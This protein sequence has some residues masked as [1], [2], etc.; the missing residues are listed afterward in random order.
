MSKFDRH[1]ERLH[2]TDEHGHRVFIFPDEIK[3][4]WKKRRTIV[5]WF[6]VLLFLGLPWIKV[7]GEQAVL[8][9]IA[10]RKFAFFGKVFWGHDAPLLIFV[11]LGF[12]V[13]MGILT[14][15]Y[16]RVWCGWACPQTVFI[17]TIFRR[18]E[19]F[20]EGSARRR[21][22]LAKASMSI[23]KLTKK[24]M[25]WILFF[26]ASTILTH[27]FLAYFVGAY[28]LH[29]I[30]TSSPTENGGKFL[31]MFI[32]NMII[33]FDFAWFRE[34]FCIIMCPYGRI[35]SV[36]MDSS[37]LVVGYDYNRGEPRKNKDVSKYE[38]GDC[39]NCYQCVKVCPTGIDIRR[40]IQLECIACTACID[41]CDNIMDRLK[42]PPGLIRYTTEDELEKKPLKKLRIRTFVYVVIFL[43]I[44]GVGGYQF[45]RTNS[46]RVL[47]LKMGNTPFRMV[48]VS[49]EEKVL[50]HFK[51]EFF[52]EGKENVEV[53]FD[54]DAKVNLEL[55][56]PQTPYIVKHAR[57]SITH[58][59]VRFKKD[60]LIN[61][62]LKINLI[63][64][65]N[66]GDEIKSQEV[67]LV[68]PF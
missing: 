28:E 35:Q 10:E 8:I 34:Q 46:V 6:L 21:E 50:N 65:D 33:L 63:L 66:T 4:V 64:K 48:K 3:G 39:V 55:V 36:M 17:D 58:L 57:K 20:V 25:K 67:T 47:F 54:H 38:Q 29:N 7:Q 43:S 62:S 2:T 61:G 1:E 26:V 22:K 27:S 41:A 18:I 16:G 59:F 23:E 44:I 12:I 5:Y 24:T 52:Y 19:E 51:V 53:F 68:G 11:L 31:A 49:G 13:L 32:L 42:K 30:V 40:G 60:V 56:T 45:D 14:S 9:N 15:L 37:S